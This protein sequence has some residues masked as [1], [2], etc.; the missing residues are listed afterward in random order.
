V[1]VVDDNVDAGELLGMLLEQ[2]GHCVVVSAD[3]HQATRL[4]A[5]FGAEV[6]VLDIGMPGLDGYELAVQMREHLGSSSPQM[7]A[8]TGYG[9]PED[10]QR[11][12]A[13]G[14]AAHL[15]KPVDPSKLLQVIAA[16][17]QPS[18]PSQAELR[19]RSL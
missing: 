16:A 6:A 8:L 18:R 11:I 3:P 14:F 9:R 1:L 2:A 12:L 4:A 7:I 19:M 15:V 5:E 17:A 10:R 13:A